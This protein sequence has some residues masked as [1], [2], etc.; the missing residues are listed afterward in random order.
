MSDANDNSINLKTTN[1]TSPVLRNAGIAQATIAAV[2][3][4]RLA[5]TSELSAKDVIENTPGSSEDEA[6]QGVVGINHTDLPEAQQA[7][8]EPE[9][10]APQAK[11]PDPIVQQPEERLETVNNKYIP[12]EPYEPT[13]NDPYPKRPPLLAPN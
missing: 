10:A 11:E 7:I 12:S 4:G 13:G 2:D 6:Y 8:E 5:V 1:S 3:S 9:I